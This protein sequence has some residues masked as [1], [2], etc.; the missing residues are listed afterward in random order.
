MSEMSQ[1]NVRIE[2]VLHTEIKMYCLQRGIML[3]DLVRIAVEEYIERSEDEDYDNND[4]I[5]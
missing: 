4:L 3:E 2:R 5:D 1:L